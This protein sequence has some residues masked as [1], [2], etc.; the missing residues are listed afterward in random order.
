M[1][2]GVNWIGV[3]VADVEA[4]TPFYRDLLGLPLIARR[5]GSAQFALTGGAVLELVPGGVA[6]EGAERKGR[7]RQS[8]QIGLAVDDLDEVRAAL[9]ARGVATG[10]VQTFEGGWRWARVVDPEGNVLQLVQRGS[11]LAP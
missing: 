7:D 8:V 5:G 9:T 3:Y 1:L 2:G 6:V 4:L 10:D 11:D